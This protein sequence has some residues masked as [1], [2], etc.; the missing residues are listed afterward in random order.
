MGQ[1]NELHINDGLGVYTLLNGTSLTDAATV[2]AA[3][4]AIAFGDLDGDGFVDAILGMALMNGAT[5]VAAPNTVHR[6]LQGGGFAHV[7]GTSI[8]AGP[9]VHTYTLALADIDGD[10]IL[11][12]FVGNWALPNTYGAF[13]SSTQQTSMV[14]QFHKGTG[15]LTFVERLA[16]DGFSFCDGA[17]STTG[18]AWGDYD[19][20]GDLDLVVVNEVS[21]NELHRNGIRKMA[22]TL[23]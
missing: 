15:N 17:A 7:R 2:D 1:P 18:A 4:M 16:S 8:S 13:E 14:N 23:D 10:G 21:V 11:D 9:D 19:A 5:S 12:L 6:N 3:T 20:D 22:R